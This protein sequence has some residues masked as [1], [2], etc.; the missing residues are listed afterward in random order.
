MINVSHFRRWCAPFV[1][2]VLGASLLTTAVCTGAESETKAKRKAEPA[3]PPPSETATDWK[4]LFDGKSLKGWKVTDFAGHGEVTVDLNFRTNAT[5]KGAPAMILDMGAALTGI[6][7]TNPPPAGSFEVSLEAMKVDG[8]DFFCGL[9]FPAGGGHCSLI[10][11][12]WGGGVVGI[13]SLDGMDAS[14]NETTKFQSF[15]SKRWYRI[16]L[17]VTQS[18][19]EAWIDEDRIVNVVITDR[20]ITVRPGEI[21]LNIPFGLAAYATKAA[22]RDIKVRTL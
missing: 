8:N 7:L 21:E 10:V 1:W 6:T 20:K 15:D 13:S 5:A 4:P 17:R 2:A 12:G 18:K 19:I 9:T 14:E 22:L 3:S 16:R 11:G